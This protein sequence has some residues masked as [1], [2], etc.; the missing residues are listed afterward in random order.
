[1][2][3]H[4][5]PVRAGLLA[6]AAAFALDQ[7]TK[8][9]V[10]E[11]VMRSPRLI[12][13][14]PFFNLTFHRNTGVSFGLFAGNGE[15]GRWALVAVALAIV[16]LLFVW[17]ARAERAWVGA[18]LGL[19]AGGAL[20]NVADRLRHGG[21]TDFLDLHYAGWHWPSFNLADVAIVCG[22]GLLLLDGLLGGR[23]DQAAGVVDGGRP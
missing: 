23:R 13:V 5:L 3:H 22:A 11:V 7:S 21:V 14:T 20:S 17:M 8:W 6:L 2:F 19:V 18:A 16:A 4:R 12:P 9:W 10:A 1:M 15:A